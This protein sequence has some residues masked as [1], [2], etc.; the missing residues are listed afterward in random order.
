MKTKAHFEQV[1]FSR[2]VVNSS[3]N[4]L[5]SSAGCNP[6]RSQQMSRNGTRRIS[7]YT[8]R[9]S[10]M[11]MATQSSYSPTISGVLSFFSCRYD[12]VSQDLDWEI[13]FWKNYCGAPWVPH[14]PSLAQIA[15]IQC[16]SLSELLVHHIAELFPGG[17]FRSPSA[18]LERFRKRRYGR[19]CQSRQHRRKCKEA[20]CAE[21]RKEG[22]SG[23]RR[24][25]WKM[26]AGEEAQG[27]DF[28]Y[29][30]YESTILLQ[31]GELHIRYC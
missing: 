25:G 22:R 30:F 6:W 21:G 2:F 5:P 14:Q 12:Q 7:T 10:Q 27:S 11:L 26:A 1:G 31:G 23:R 20:K 19:S 17:L 8:S 13:F 4:L 15:F 18:H 3:L 16:T 24:C 29:D 9:D 28:F